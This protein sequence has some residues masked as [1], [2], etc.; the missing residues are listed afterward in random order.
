MYGMWQT[1]LIVQ[2][3]AER[4]A[5]CCSWMWPR[6]SGGGRLNLVGLFRVLN[7]FRRTNIFIVWILNYCRKNDGNGWRNLPPCWNPWGQVEIILPLFCSSLNVRSLFRVYLRF[8]LMTW[9][10][11]WAIL[12]SDQPSLWH[13]HCGSPLHYCRLSIQKEK[14]NYFIGYSAFYFKQFSLMRCFFFWKA[15]S[16]RFVIARASFSERV[17]LPLFL[18][19]CVHFQWGWEGGG[20]NRVPLKSKSD[21][22][23]TY[24]LF[25]AFGS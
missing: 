3:V 11:H 24:V 15:T 12:F 5:S 1:E 6:W 18:S 22:C 16:E 4:S 9:S 7:F 19:V 2:Y 8:P 10:R 23:R 13:K 14:N 17:V 21:V 20:G 25:F